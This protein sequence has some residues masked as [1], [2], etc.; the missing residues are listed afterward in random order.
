MTKIAHATAADQYQEVDYRFCCS[1]SVALAGYI[2]Q[3]S[4]IESVNPASYIVCES[5]RFTC[6]REGRADTCDIKAELHC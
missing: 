4:A 6:M 2:V 1:V 3:T 5:P